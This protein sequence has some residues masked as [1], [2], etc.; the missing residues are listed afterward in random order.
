MQAAIKKKVEKQKKKTNEQGGGA[1]DIQTATSQSARHQKSA[2]IPRVMTEEDRESLD[3]KLE[4]LMEGPHRRE[5]EK[6]EEEEPVDLLPIV[7]S[8]F[9]QVGPICCW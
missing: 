4:E 5:K 6:E 7:D 1:A 9:G 3:E 2:Q 8:V